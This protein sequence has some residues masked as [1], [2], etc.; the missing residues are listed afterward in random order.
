MK[1]GREVDRGQSMP[2]R[3]RDDQ[4]AMSSSPT[5]RRHDQTA[6]RR[7]RERGERALDLARIAHVDRAAPPRRATAPRWIAANCRSQAVWQA[8]RRTAARVTPGATSLSSSS[9]FAADAVFERVKPVALPPGRARL[10]TKP[11]PTGSGTA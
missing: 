11:A 3:E 8:S 2:R 1:S 5:A 7:E 9:H 10:S 6:V 4:L